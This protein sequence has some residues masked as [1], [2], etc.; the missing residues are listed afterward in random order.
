M[1]PA[2]Q[3]DLETLLAITMKMRK[4][5]KDYFRDRQQSV[6]TAAKEAEAQVDQLVTRLT[7]RQ[8]SMF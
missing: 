7:T 1:D 2:R 3:A 5:Q 8:T 4:L 6:L